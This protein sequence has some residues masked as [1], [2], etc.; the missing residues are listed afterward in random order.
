MNKEKSPPRKRSVARAR[1]ER[2]LDPGTFEE[3][4]SQVLHRSTD[5]G[6]E[7]KRLPG[8]GVITGMGQIEG[9]PVFVFAQ[10]RTV[11]GGSLGQAHAAKITKIYDLALDSRVPVIGI[12]DSGGARIQEGVD[13]LGGYGELFRRNVAASGVIPQISLIFGPC[14]GGAVYSPALTD[15]VGMVADQSFMFLTGPRVVKT[16]T[17]EE[18]TTE[19]LG[20]ANVHAN[21]SG[22]AH[23]LFQN[24]T[25]ALEQTR[26]LLSY[27]PSH[28]DEAP[29]YQPPTDPMDRLPQELETMVPENPKES[30]DI[31]NIIQT[32]MDQGSFFETHAM[33]APNVVVGLA[34]LGGHPVGVVANQPLSM[35]G[36]LD[37]NA[38][39]KAARL[40]RTCNAFRIPIVSF[41]D[42]PGFLPGSDQEYNGVIN[43]GAKLLYAYC[44]ATVP[45]LSVILR[46]AYGGAYLVMSSKHIGGDINLAW[47]AAEIAVMGAKG[48]VE[49]LYARELRGHDDPQARRAELEDEY[50]QEFLSPARAAQRGYIDEVIAPCETRRKLFR[51]L[52]AIRTK[53]TNPIPRH[54]GNIPL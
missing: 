51:Y 29:P 36:V 20:G 4:G 26:R 50:K 23:L 24:E 53:Q 54:N 39:R 6:L 28:C 17:F 21:T 33:W 30:Y 48:A 38:S 44:E 2:L 25:E 1:L 18:I 14:A 16:V 3:I 13:S 22:V 37:S 49:I 40:I 42:V 41:V 8:D 52:E 9:R 11:L 34:R 32:V 46:K 31:R 27:L 5:F 10:D 35:A 7:K 15:F 19:D 47:P 43:H 12:N 45:K